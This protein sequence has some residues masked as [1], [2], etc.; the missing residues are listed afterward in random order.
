MK[1]ISLIIFD[2]DGTLVN[3]LEDITASVN[4]TLGRFGM[5]PLA[6]DTVRR[7]VG[8]GIEMLMM[9]SLGGRQSLLAEAVD[10]YKAHH[11]ENLT[12]R[13]SLYPTVP[14]TL[15]YFKALPMAVISNKSAE[16]VGPLLA[17]LGI[18]GYFKLIVG[19]E[20]SV[21]LK[22][23]PDAI[24]R[25]MDSLGIPKEGTVMVG[26]GIADVLAG[27][28]AGVI[29]CSVTYGFRSEEELR[30]AG[31]DYLIHEPSDLRKLFVPMTQ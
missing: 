17:R 22:P 11:R 19:A 12:V 27:K 13:S 21:P 20:P 8:D 25:I 7:F 1:Q 5:P 10:V 15:D 29:T 3:T 9:R 28:A 6:M 30:R 24:L 16:F 2:L 14:E 26:D 4:F 23:A 31:P 18:A